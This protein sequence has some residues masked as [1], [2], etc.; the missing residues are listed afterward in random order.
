MMI[1]F[2]SEAYNFHI[3]NRLI[4]LLEYRA[5]GTRMLSAMATLEEVQ[6]VSAGLVN[7]DTRLAATIAVM[8]GMAG[9]W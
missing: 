6:V 1:P 4:Y 7:I 8:G 9:T 2:D 5:T 3:R